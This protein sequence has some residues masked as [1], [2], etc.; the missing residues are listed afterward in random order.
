MAHSTNIQRKKGQQMNKAIKA[1]KAP[2]S[3][4][5]TVHLPSIETR[6]VAVRLV[7]LNSLI[8]HRFD[9][10]AIT[11]MLAKQRGLPF[12]RTK[13][14]PQ[15]DF[16][17]SKYYNEN[18]EDCV[19]VMTVKK[20]MTEMASFSDNI[21]KKQVRAGFMILGEYAPLKY[22][23][24]VMRQDMVRT[25]G[26]SRAPDVR[27]RAM[28]TGWSVDLVIQ[29]DARLITLDEIMYLARGAGTSIGICEWRIQ[30]DGIYGSFEVEPLADTQVAAIVKA[31]AI[32]PKAMVL[33]EWVMREINTDE[34]L[35]EAIAAAKRASGPAPI[36]D[37][38]GDDA[39]DP[40]SEN[41][42]DENGESAVPFELAPKAK[43]KPGRPAKNGAA[44]HEIS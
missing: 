6:R 29:F 34:D 38:T 3:R 20:A 9:E 44:K 39:G 27:F 10:K 19:P 37:D 12:E 40:A 28:Y 24:C 7:G 11:Q 36:G 17:A 25:S 1:T 2:A 15:R 22:D 26:I 35:K 5:Q 18:G 21:T 13:K 14:A 16:E 4:E 23:N 43:R 42:Q 41:A 8:V 32:P 31:C 33:P 30:K